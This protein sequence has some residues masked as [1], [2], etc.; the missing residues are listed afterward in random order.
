MHPINHSHSPSKNHSL[1]EPIYVD[2]VY[3]EDV[4]QDDPWAR[5]DKTQEEEPPKPTLS[6]DNEEDEKDENP[7]QSPLPPVKPVQPRSYRVK[8]NPAARRIP[9]HRRIT[10]QKGLPSELPRPIRRDRIPPTDSRREERTGSWPVAS[11]P[12][13]NGTA[14]KNETTPPSERAISP[15]QNPPERTSSPTLFPEDA[16][17]APLLERRAP[18]HQPVESN[19]PPP[20]QPKMPTRPL[21]PQRVFPVESA[22]PTAVDFRPLVDVVPDETLSGEQETAEEH[23][24][25]TEIPR[26]HTGL[27]ELIGRLALPPNSLILGVCDDGLPLVLELSAPSPGALLCLGDDVNGLRKH[28]QSVLV[29]V[30]SLSDQKQVQ[31]DIITPQ[32]ETFSAQKR[33]PHV[34]RIHLPDQDEMF[35]LLGCLFDMIEQ[36]QRKDHSLTGKLLKDFL[37]KSKDP[38]RILLIDQLDVLVEQLAPE[39]LAY[40]RWLLRRGPAA[41]VWVLASLNVRNAQ[42]VDGKTLKSF[43]LQI[44]GNLPNTRQSARLT[45]LPL[46][47]LSTLV[48]GGQACLKLDEDVIEFSIQEI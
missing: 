5:K 6:F 13:R 48:T 26:T 16:E 34:Q 23:W 18:P 2:E 33:L 22:T 8:T 17:T 40:L 43:G 7:V 11:T 38:F 10:P 41:N 25:K 47:K 36:R 32:P 21:S 9:D 45:D 19:T 12:K 37:P 20:I 1:D 35:D 27:H 15:V 3:P 14:P 42:T 30:C 28:L 31:I 29:S 24:E 46:D 4:N 39:S 44:A